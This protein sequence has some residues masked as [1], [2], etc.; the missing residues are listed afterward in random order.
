MTLIGL[1]QP[2]VE[3]SASPISMINLSYHRFSLAQLYKVKKRA[4]SRHLL[5]E[6]VS[7]ELCSTHNPPPQCS[8]EHHGSDKKK[9]KINILMNIL[10]I[11]KGSELAI[12][13]S[14]YVIHNRSLIVVPC[15]PTKLLSAIFSRED[16]P[17]RETIPGGVYTMS[18]VSRTGLSSLEKMADNSFVGAQ[19]TTIRER[20]WIT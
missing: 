7:H 6:D 19:G 12:L 10:D 14:R 18:R 11:Y 3:A 1:K 17:V 9:R 4:R 15:A 5:S 13:S 16:K 8:N 20:L 2:S